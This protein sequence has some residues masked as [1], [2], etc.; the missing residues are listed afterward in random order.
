VGLANLHSAANEPRLEEPTDARRGFSL[1]SRPAG[2]LSWGR[3]ARLFLFTF[4]LLVAGM[5]ITSSPSLFRTASYEEGDDAANALQIDRAK[6][7]REIHGNYSRWAFHHPGPAFFYVYALGEWTLHDLTHLVPAPRNAHILVGA[8]LQLAFFA[9]AIALVAHHTRAPLLT[10]G[11]AL[12][13]AAWRYASVDGVL[14]SVWPPHV[15]LMPFL[16]FLV[17]CAAVSIGDGVALPILVLAGGFL[18]HGHIAQP[19]FVGPM[20]LAAIIAAIRRWRGHLG[21]VARSPAGVFSVALVLVFALPIVIDLCAGKASNAHDV[22][23]HLKYQTDHGKTLLKSLLCYASYFIGMNDPSMFNK[24][25]A[26]THVPFVQHA[27]LLAGWLAVLGSSIWYFVKTRHRDGEDLR[28]GRHLLGFWVLASACTLVWGMRQDGGFTSFNSHFN[29]SLVYA[30]ALFAI[31]ALTHL[32][33]ALPRFLGGGLAVSG[34]VAFSLMLPYPLEVGTRGNDADPR[35]QAL[36][37]ADPRPHAPKLLLIDV[38]PEREEWYEATTLARSLQRRGIPF[39]VT[40]DWRVMFGESN[41]FVN[42]G[43]VLNHGGISAWRIIDRRRA[44]AGAHKL[45]RE[46]AVAY[47][48]TATLRAFPLQVAFAAGEPTPP[49]AI[50][51]LPVTTDANWAWTLANVVAFEFN[52]PRASGDLELVLDAAG[53]TSQ[54][55]PAGQRAIVSVNGTVVGRHTFNDDRQAV[56]YNVPRAAW[57]AHSPCVITIDLPDAMSPSQ[58]A[59]SNER[60][61]LGLRLH[62]LTVTPVA[63]AR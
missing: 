2:L 57:N 13:V 37:D 62:R 39:Y 18:V 9:A 43:D 47:V 27:G 25:S 29:H 49:Y 21:S 11:L 32:L 28:F 1:A 51:G 24:L 3:M 6:H 53:F 63:A 15:L 61:V 60:R 48:P 22:W 41:V 50:Y 59:D 20:G 23:L 58:F 17:A 7:L 42:Q 5:T 16:C 14:Y 46:A 54:P 10:I 12:A 55:S 35:V 19:L 44:P 56:R 38:V 45:N 8:L 40:P 4:L 30:V 36:L 52:A 26:T 33:P 31:V 34:A